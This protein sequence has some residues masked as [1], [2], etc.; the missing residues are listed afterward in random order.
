LFAR[1]TAFNKMATPQR[2]ATLSSWIWIEFMHFLNSSVIGVFC[3]KEKFRLLWNVWKWL[4]FQIFT[5]VP[6]SYIEK[7]SYCHHKHHELCSFSWSLT[8]F[9]TNLTSPD[10]QQDVRVLLMAL[11]FPIQQQSILI[12][13]N[14][15]L[16]LSD[17][18][19]R[20][21]LK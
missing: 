21:T 17:L 1:V 14:N 18:T 5:S 20:W 8:T 10:W 4:Q 11:W 7:C 19:L 3:V 16:W 6:T 13:V 15:I 12:S 2:K 9:H